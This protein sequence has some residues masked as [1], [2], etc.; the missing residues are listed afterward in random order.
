TPPS[1]DVKIPVG[2]YDPALGRTYVQIARQGWGE[3]KSQN[4]G[5]NPV[6]S[7]PDESEYHL[8]AV[9]PAAKANGTANAANDDLFHNGRVDIDTSIEGIARLAG[10]APPAWLTEGLQRIQTEI[11]GL[12]AACP[13]VD[14]VAAAHKLAPVYR[15]LLALRARVAAGGLAPE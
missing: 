1:V 9:A 4:G 12:Q 11:A 15:D 10:S 14:T 7:S 5:S 6:L 8:W 13:C 2:A 3:Q